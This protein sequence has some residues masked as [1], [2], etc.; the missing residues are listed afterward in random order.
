MGESWE[1]AYLR[2]MAAKCRR[3]AARLIDERAASSLRKLAEE[4]EAA[5]NAELELKAFNGRRQ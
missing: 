1:E 2:E 4:Y 5:L 3:L